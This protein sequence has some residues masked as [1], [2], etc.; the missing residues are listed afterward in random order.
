MIEEGIETLKNVNRSIDERKPTFQLIGDP[1]DPIMKAFWFKVKC[2][3]CPNEVLQL[4]P[5]KRNLEANLMN[6][7]HGVVHCKS[8]EDFQRK[9]GSALS[10]GKRGRPSR[11][12]ASSSHSIQ[13]GLHSFF[14]HSEG[15]SL[16]YDN[17]SISARTCWGL[18]GPCCVYARKSYA[19]DPLLFD[20]HPG[21][22]W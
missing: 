8:V 17:T 11:P 18:R 15:E 2:V 20:P 22:K 1:N 4:C 16:S 6:H 13:A 12:S 3:I 5:P 21:K 19:I 9:E 14:K 10:T 7:V